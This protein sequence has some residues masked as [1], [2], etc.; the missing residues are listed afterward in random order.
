MT[1]PVED[2]QSASPP[3]PSL[4]EAARGQT[5]RDKTIGG[6]N[7]LRRV[8]SN[9]RGEVFE[10][11]DPANGERVVLKTAPQSESAG[12]DAAGRD[13]LEREAAIL[14]GLDHPGIA[15]LMNLREI[16]DQYVLVLK[17]V[18][19]RSLE[20]ILE[21]TSRPVDE[22]ELRRFLAGLADAV[23]YLHGKSILHR[24][25]KPENVIVDD[26]GQPIIVDFGNARDMRRG[27]A[28]A[29]AYATPGYCA[30]ELYRAPRD[31]GPWTDVYSLAAIAYRAVAG[32][33]PASAETPSTAA[34]FEPLTAIGGDN[35]TKGF[36]ESI[37]RSLSSDPRRRP[38]SAAAFHALMLSS[39]DPTKGGTA[40]P[41]DRVDGARAAAYPPTVAV[42]QRALAPVSA[43]AR[44]HH[45][46][47]S[48]RRRK[49]GP[50]LAAALGIGL[51]AAAAA[52]QAWPL[53]L[54]YVKS[55]WVVDAAGNGDTRRLSDALSQARDGATI[56]V[57][58]GTYRESLTMTRSVHLTADPHA[59]E[60]AVITPIAGS[61]LVI[62]SPQGSVTG[63]HF[64][65]EETFGSLSSAC[66]VLRAGNARITENV[67]HHARGT[68]IL[69][70][71]GAG[72]EISGN[73][74]ENSGGA[75][76]MIRGGAAPRVVGNTIEASKGT[77]MVVAEGGRGLYEDNTVSGSVRSGLEVAS[78]AAP[79]FIGNNIAGSGEAGLYLYGAAG[80]VFEDN[81]FFENALGGIIIENGAGPSLRGN[82][83]E[84]NGEH[85]VIV[86]N[87]S[88][89]LDANIVRD[90][91]GHGIAIAEETSVELGENELSG[92][93]EPELLTK[94]RPKTR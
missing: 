14:A 38:Q 1:R 76:L 30:P 49:R 86:L 36:L 92:N 79:R 61:C 5:R 81:R 45:E 10:A 55:T 73:I 33:A 78:G 43:P 68:G 88:A 28:G 17:H 85:G 41:A 89:V 37:D 21:T 94:A 4:A 24:D 29:P 44:T 7:V 46:N 65:T 39:D 12:P 2:P 22:G 70:V 42:A 34:T 50:L 16:D 3:E 47:V 25:L 13:R 93:K 48:G 90:N 19:G 58:A 56:V 82:V 62:S 26:K 75:G 54:R 27:G 66:L 18:E 20:G 9:P 40:A 71:A 6:F 15:R 74:I 32:R 11:L 53:Y 91:E 59:A 69:I 64:R 31:E 72:G 8:A 63:L 67:I 51:L 60:P 83:V 35:Y 57:R 52:W 87:G 23:T 80:G 84:K 77:G